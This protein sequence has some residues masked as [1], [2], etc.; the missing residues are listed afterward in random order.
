MI[1]KNTFYSSYLY[2]Y[3]GY[4]LFLYS[5]TLWNLEQFENNSCINNQRG[6]KRR[7][8]EILLK[9]EIRQTYFQSIETLFELI[10]ALK[11]KGTILFDND[12]HYRLAD[13]GS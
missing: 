9:S 8:L 13:S 12:I 1:D 2:D 10:F 4:K 3:F 7:D 6:Y 11:P 5:I